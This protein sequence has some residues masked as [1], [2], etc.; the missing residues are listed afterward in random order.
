M[1]W[2][3]TV[4][5]NSSGQTYFMISVADNSSAKIDNVTVSVNI[6][7]EITSLGNLQLNGAQTSGDIVSGINIGSLDPGTAKTITFEGKA[8]NFTNKESKQATATATVSGASQS[9]TLT[10]N[11]NP[12]NATAGETA[13]TSSG[14]LGFLKKWYLWILAA[15]VLVFLFVV[16]FKRLSSNA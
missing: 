10:I 15:I 13:K 11:L 14:F 12:T 16:V 1:Q 4:Q 7:V 6:P 2:E 9:D 5:A 3:K 8:E